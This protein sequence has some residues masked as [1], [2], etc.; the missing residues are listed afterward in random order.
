LSSRI[1]GEGRVSHTSTALARMIR[2]SKIERRK[3]EGENH[4]FRNKLRRLKSE[5]RKKEKDRDGENHG[6]RNKLRRLKSEERK[7]ERRGETREYK[8]SLSSRIRGRGKSVSQS[9]ALARMIRSSKKLRENGTR[10]G[11]A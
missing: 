10:S 3:R 6:F 8:I 4:G 5:E 1:R 2:N 7:R 9:T 11:K